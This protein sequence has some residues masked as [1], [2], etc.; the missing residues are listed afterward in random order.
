MEKQLSQEELQQLK[1]LQS[2][3]SK[4]YFEIGQLEIQKRSLNEELDKIKTNQDYL[5][6]DI[7]KIQENEEIFAKILNEK[8]GKGTIDINTGKISPLE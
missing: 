7:K 2:S 8:Y 4:V 5:F 1:E 3:Y 6:L